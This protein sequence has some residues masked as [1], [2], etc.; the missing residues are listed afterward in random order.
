MNKIVCVLLM[1]ISLNMY[2]QESAVYD[3][4]IESK[5]ETKVALKIKV[6][7]AEK[8][9]YKAQDLI[10]KRINLIIKDS[11]KHFD[12]VEMYS[13]EK[14]VMEQIINKIYKN[15]LNNTINSVKLLEV[16]VPKEVII[17]NEKLKQIE[18]TN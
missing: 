8:A 2:S 10:I 16:I 6:N 12:A 11:L 14:A 18:H 17:L 7:Y 13:T 1:L 3:L 15:K 4:F 9:I 5:Y